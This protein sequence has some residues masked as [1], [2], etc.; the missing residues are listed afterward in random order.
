MTKDGQPLAWKIVTYASRAEFPIFSQVLQS[1]A[2]ELGI[3]ITIELV[4]NYEDYLMSNDSWDIGMYSPLISPRGDAS[5][6]LNVAFLPDGT[7]NY[8]RIN[9]EELNHLIDQLD[10]TIDTDIRNGL[11]RQALTRIDEQTYYSYLIHPNILVAYKDKVEN[12]VTSKSE[13]YM[14]TNHLD[15]RSE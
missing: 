9:D 2:K 8:G 7:L 5:Y 14:L 4:G 15:V 13:Y 6:F 11:I 3:T 1:K 10:Q 12:W